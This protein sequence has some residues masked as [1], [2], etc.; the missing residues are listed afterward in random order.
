V[1]LAAALAAAGSPASALPVRV[2]L[3]WASAKPASAPARAHIQAVR[4]AGFTQG[5]VPVEAEAGPDGVVLDLG[6][7]VWELQAAAPGYWSPRAEVAVSGQAPASVLLALWPAAAL[8]GEIL[9]D[10]GGSLPREVEARLTAVPAHPGPSHA[11]LRCAIEE[12]TW[13]CPGPAGVFDVQLETAS[14]A[15]RY[16]WDVTLQA[17]A[18]TDLGPTVLRRAASVFG[19]A[20]RSDGS[21]PEGP[22]RATL[23]ADGARRGS[24]EPGPGIASEDDA[25]LSVP[26]S[27]RGFFHAVGLTA[28]SQVL[29]VECPAASARRALRVQADG[30]TRIDPPLLLEELTL[31]V[32]VTPKVDGEGR[33]WQLTVDATAP[34]ARRIADKATVSADGG[35]LRRGLTAGSYRVAVQSADGT[36]WLQRVFGLGPGSGPLS[37]QVGVVPVAGQ[38]RLGTQPLRARLVFFNEAGGEP[39]TIASDEDGR[40]EGLLPV[41]AG[42]LETRWTVEAHAAQPPINRRLEGVRVQATAGDA[43]AWLEL[44]LPMV[45]VRGTV[46]SE[47]GALQKGAAVT[48]EDTSNGARTV[49]ATDE[50]GSFELAELPAGSYTAVAQSADGV[51]APTAI[52]VVDGV[53][54]E[55]K[56]VLNGSERVAFYV[57]SDQGPVPDAAVQVWMAP[58]VPRNFTRTDRDGR[59]EVDLPPGTTDLGL[60]VGAAGHALK[61]TRRVVPQEQTIVLGASAGRLVLDLEARGRPGGDVTTPYLVHD[62]A[63]EAAGAL[64]GWGAAPGAGGAS[65]VIE[66]IEPGAYALCLAGPDELATLW[67]GS[68]PSERCRQGSL[69]AGGTLTLSPP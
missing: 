66:A 44:A 28:G 26:L 54:S 31:A 69:A 56:L 52:E 42:V 45:A 1:A 63:I 30:E 36:P 43:K 11:E 47:D 22:C 34:W 67:R 16:A 6:D 53:E 10:G 5:G 41:A 13:S 62:G 29:S 60:T 37:L 48:F 49:A 14:Y 57:V 55:L 46:V 2:T 3:D 21:N 33:P 4:T 64:A 20:T 51:S 68:L 65:T 32:A 23:Q 17:G 25:I 12:G 8:H 9:T 50:A 15:P 24:P 7:G 27:R 61:L 39:L 58:G 40:F 19:R 59:F 38:V 35:W 18:S